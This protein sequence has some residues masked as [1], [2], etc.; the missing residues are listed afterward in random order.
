MVY[1]LILPCEVGVKTVLPAVKAV[2]AR[3]IVEKHGL[4]EK[5]TAKLLGLSQSAV[6]RY[7]SRERGNLLAIENTA[8]VLTLIDQMVSYLIKEPDKKMEMMQLFCQICILVREKG[9][10]CP[11]CQKEMAK[12]WAHTCLFCR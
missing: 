10:M 8:E 5:Q 1:N 2:M 4:R 11:L 7:V 3:T 9:L 12:N 6:S